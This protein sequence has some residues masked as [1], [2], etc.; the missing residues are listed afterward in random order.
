MSIA[1]TT[2]YWTSRMNGG[3]P[4]A[5]TEYGQDNAS[6][7]LTGT[8][9]DGSAVG[10]SWQIANV[11]SGQY[12]SVTPTTNDYT[13]VACFKFTS[14]PTN[15]TV[16]MEVDNGTHKAQVQATGDLQ[17][18]KLV[19]A[20]TVTITDLDLAQTDSFDSVPIM[21]RLTLN[22]AGVA[23]MYCREII[24]DDTGV[25]N[26]LQVTGASGSSKTIKWGNN[27]GTVL[28]NNVYTSTFG[29]YSPDELSTS[30]FVTDSLMRMSLSIVE[31]LQN[32]KRF[33]LKNQVAD[34]SILYGYDISS[35]MISRIPQPSVHVIL[36]KLDSPDFSTLGGTR[37]EQNY[38]VIIFITTR[39]TDYKNA[40]RMGLEIAG[41]CFDELY[42]NT[43]LK[44]N[45]DSLT[46]YEI[47]FD[48]KMDDDEVVCV[49]RLEVTYM[50]RLNMLHR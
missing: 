8:A 11:G 48:T 32:S 44:G 31:L 43:G 15:N 42:T 28:W 18:L 7:S 50:R 47:N 45:T 19:G 3:N 16:L 49:H 17:T 41:D 36:R 46:N 9:D 6:Y 24:E 14:V 33:Y 10:D 1:T 23:T 26:Y 34:A 13:V 22:T 35:Q 37:I 25:V 39:G 30:P 2:E 21:V 20:T 12:W 29:A 38:T 4:G 40:Y 27:S 5:L